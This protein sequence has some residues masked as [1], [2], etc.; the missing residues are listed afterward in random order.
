MKSRS[1]VLASAASLLA[2]AASAPAQADQHEGIEEAATADD[3]DPNSPEIGDWGVDL[4][5]RDTAVDPG[6]DFNA[7][8]S[9]TWL[10]NTEIPGDRSRYG[11]FDILRERSENQVHEILDDLAADPAAA[12][13]VGRKVGEFYGAWM[14]TAA[15][16][17]RGIAPLAPYLERI[18]AIEVAKTCSKSLEPS[19]TRHRSASA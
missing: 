1:F 2:I 3:A 9:G 17:A 7:Y 18:D 15:I 8:A 12:G 14:D 11:S 19:V 4:S 6:D 5:A 16:E 13:P 10:A